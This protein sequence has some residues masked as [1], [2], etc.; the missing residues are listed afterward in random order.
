MRR[1]RTKTKVPKKR[2]SAYAVAGAA[3]LISS[4]F[5]NADIHCVE[6]G[7]TVLDDVPGDNTF[8]TPFSQTFGVP[9]VALQFMHSMT[10]NLAGPKMAVNGYVS[11]S[12]PSSFAMSI[13]GS[14]A[15][16]YLFFFPDNLP[17]NQTLSN[18]NFVSA[19]DANF[20]MMAWGNGAQS[21][22]RSGFL[23]TGGYIG[24]R[25]DVG[26][27]TQYGWSLLTLDEGTP[28]NIFTVDTICWA[29]PG[30]HL[31]VGQTVPESSSLAWL[32]LGAIGIVSWRRRRAQRHHQIAKRKFAD[33]SWAR[34]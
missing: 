28:N 22:Y 15:P 11:V 21:S 23:D 18:L 4:G 33:N 34:R 25:F 27:G 29:D 2:W 12:A 30:Q 8:G 16:S 6:P 31:R 5:A 9:G 7:I 17:Y 3:T 26:N 32:A 10:Y 13:A 24:F 19:D 1:N 20:G 14:S